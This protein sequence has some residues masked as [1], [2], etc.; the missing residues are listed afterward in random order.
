[1]PGALTAGP[2][3]ENLLKSYKID[4]TNFK[5][6]EFSSKIAKYYDDREDFIT[7]E[8]TIVGNATAIFVFGN[9]KEK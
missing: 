9:L 6:D 7:N 2:A 3:P 8:P 1:M 4:R 5:Y